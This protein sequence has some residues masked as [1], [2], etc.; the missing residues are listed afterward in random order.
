MAGRRPFQRMDPEENA[1]RVT[2]VSRALS[3]FRWAYMPLGLLA[4]I[5]VGVHAAADAIDDRILWVVDHLDAGFDG[6]FGA[7]KFTSGLVDLVG[8]EQRVKLARGLALGW[9]LLVDLLL[10]LPALGY[11]EK[12]RSTV[13]PLDFA[14]HPERTGGFKALLQ[15]F[16]VQ[17]TSVRIIRPFASAAVVTAGACAIARMVQGQVYLSGRLLV[18]DGTA[19]IAA[20]LLAIGVLGLV[21]YSLGWRAVL[22]NLEHADELSREVRPSPRNALVHGLWGSLAVLP[23]AVAALWDASPVLSFFR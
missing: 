3:G 9:E 11:H 13:R 23:L 2:K 20:R 15:R 10:A 5:A 12:E 22:R 6:V 7:W 17:P 14:L 4:L 18:G 16:K 19:G 8:L 21:L 1:S